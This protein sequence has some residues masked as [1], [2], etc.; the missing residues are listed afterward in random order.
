MNADVEQDIASAIGQAVTAEVG[1]AATVRAFTVDDDA[2]AVDEAT[3]YPAVGIVVGPAMEHEPGDVL[4]QVPVQIVVGTH[5]TTDRKATGVAS[6][7]KSVRHVLEDEDA[8]DALI[9]GN[10][11]LLGFA[12]PDTGSNA[13]AFQPGEVEA[14][15]NAQGLQVS[16]M[17]AVA[18]CDETTTTT[19]TAP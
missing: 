16:L 10:I 3:A 6:L 19:T 1:T 15:P 9:P 8:I 17:A 7:W 4:F 18:A 11:R 2:T 13:R 14:M 12:W 5:Y